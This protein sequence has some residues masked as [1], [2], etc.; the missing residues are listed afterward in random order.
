[1]AQ[2][3]KKRGR[4]RPPKA[5]EAMLTPIPVRF[6]LAMVEAIEAIQAERMDQP[7]KSAIIRELV[8]EALQARA[9]RK[10]GQ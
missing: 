1:V 7:D 8:A 9:R 5:K 4:G 6:P 2:Q 3:P 10:G